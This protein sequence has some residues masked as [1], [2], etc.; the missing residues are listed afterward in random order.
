MKFHVPPKFNQYGRR[1]LWIVE[2][3]DS[4]LDE[5]INGALTAVLVLGVISLLPLVL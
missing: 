4:G 3:E 2:S 5:V 1:Q